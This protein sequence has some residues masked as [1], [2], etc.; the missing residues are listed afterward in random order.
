MQPANASPLIRLR[1]MAADEFAPFRAGFIADWA[2]DLA[3]IDDLSADAAVA[4][5]TART[6]ADLPRGTETPGH[7]L[8]VILADEAPIGTLWFSMT[9]EGDAFLDDITVGGAHRGQGHG[10]IALALA[11]EE[12]RRRGAARM[13]LHV[14]R[15]N[16]RAIAL[17]EAVG[18]R[19]TGLKM[20]KLLAGA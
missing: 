5:A 3:K 7:H 20:R 6:D 17:Y 1:P 16:P 12:A 15:H 8:F 19:T 18:Y 14:Y 2:L 4:R 10:R 11:E 9:A 13:E